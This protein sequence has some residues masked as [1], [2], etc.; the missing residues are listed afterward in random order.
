M[1]HE[2]TPQ[3]IAELPELDVAIV[4]LR[5]GD[6]F[7]LQYREDDNGAMGLIGGFGG[8]VEEE[9]DGDNA[10]RAII[11]EVA[12]EVGIGEDK[13]TAKP[14]ELSQHDFLSQGMVYVVSDRDGESRF[15]N[16]DIF[17]A[18]LKVG[19][20]IVA[21]KGQ[22]RRM[23]QNDLMKAKAKKELTPATQEALERY[24]DI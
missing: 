16:G 13:T 4:I 17:E 2:L 7:L 18:W 1:T 22:L 21:L 8:M 6:D 23:R 15:I 24:Y 14:L 5:Q 12:E 9:K 20:P 11:R 3:E 10:L 19:M